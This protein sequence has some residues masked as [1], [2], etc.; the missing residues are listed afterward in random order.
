MELKGYGK[1][2]IWWILLWTAY[3]FCL[4][5]KIN[6]YVNIHPI[7]LIIPPLWLVASV[8]KNGISIN[9]KALYERNWIVRVDGNELTSI[10]Y[11]KKD[12][13]LNISTIQKISIETND[14][15]PY[16]T[17]VWWHIEGD[18]ARVSIPGGATGENEMLKAFGNL[19]GFNHEEVI[20]AMGSTTNK[21]FLVYQKN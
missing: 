2:S 11:H 21:T 5:L 20:H 1:V 12:A 14:S 10:D 18:G 7:A 17:D 9:G 16:N 19:D 13:K 6:G 15:G 3:A 4:L 8:F